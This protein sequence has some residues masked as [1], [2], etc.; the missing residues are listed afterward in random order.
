MRDV[1][2]AKKARAFELLEEG[3]S[4]RDIAEEI[5]V[6]KSTVQRWAKTKGVHFPT[7]KR[8]GQRDIDE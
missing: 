2:D 1:E 4:Y 5:K 3:M 8:V 7:P 6:G